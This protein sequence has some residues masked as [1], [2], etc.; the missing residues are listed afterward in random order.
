MGPFN[1]GLVFFSFDMSKVFL[2]FCV[3]VVFMYHYLH[4]IIIRNIV[5]KNPLVGFKIENI[6]ELNK[7]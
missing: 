7:N 2:P 4:S 6:T 3:N 1:L 5:L